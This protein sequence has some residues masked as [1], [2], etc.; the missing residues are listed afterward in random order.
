MS[1][2]KDTHAS[3]KVHDGPCENT[4]I[5]KSTSCGE[6]FFGIR[7]N[8]FASTT[9]SWNDGSAALSDGE[10]ISIKSDGRVTS[11]WKHGLRKERKK[12]DATMK[13]TTATGSRLRHLDDG[14]DEPCFVRVCRTHGSPPQQGTGIGLEQKLEGLNPRPNFSPT[15]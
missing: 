6:H 3:H 14:N 10:F 1:V 4:S 7:K 5:L 12:T 13:P 8:F 2:R 9:A 15:R 11:G